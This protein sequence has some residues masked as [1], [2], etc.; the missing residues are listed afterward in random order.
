M[1]VKK[2]VLSA[3][4][5]GAMLAGTA[6]VPAAAVNVNNFTDV[7]AT[8]WFYSGVKYVAE[9]DY[10]IGVTDTLF[11]P[12]REVT[13]AMFVVI[14]YR[15][16]GEPAAGYTGFADVP[17]G[18]WC[19]K[20]VAW[21]SAN[22]IVKGFDS[23][24]FGPNSPISREQMCVMMDRFLDYRAK[25]ED[26]TFKSTVAEKT[27]QDAATIGD[28]AKEAVKTC[29]ML[30]LMEGN[31]EG[32]FNPK[33]STNRAE[34]AVVIQRLDTL[35]ATD[36]EKDEDNE[37]G[38]GG[39]GGGGGGTSTPKANY[40][41]MAVL[42][43]P[44]EEFDLNLM[45]QYNGITASSAA[46]TFSDMMYDLFDG[47]ENENAVKNAINV[48]LGK[49]KGK[50]V[51]QTVD[52]QQV[53]VSVSG[54]G[55]ISASMAVKVTD[56][57][58]G[59]Q[60]FALTSSSLEDLIGKLQGGGDLSF[61][62]EDIANMGDLVTEIEKV[63]GMTDKEIQDKIDEVVAEKPELEQA[64]SGMTPDAV[65]DAADDYKAQVNDVL[66]EV[67]SNAGVQVEK[68][69]KGNVIIPAPE[70]IPDNI[71]EVVVKKDP[72]VM[73][74]A[75]D[76]GAY[77]T[78]ILDKYNA[79]DTKTEYINRLEE[80][81]GL[82]LT[83]YQEFAAMGLYQVYNPANF[84]EDNGDKTLSLKDAQ[85]Y[86]E[87]VRWS[88]DNSGI[89]LESLGQDAAFYQSLLEK[90]FSSSE[91]VETLASLM[92]DPN[93]VLSDETGLRGDLTVSVTKN[94]DEDTYDSILDLIA[95]KN[96]QIGSILPGEMPS[97]LSGLL[98]GYTITLTIDNLNE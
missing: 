80:Q 6:A 18:T 75:M 16:D 71:E 58:G 79:E 72:V 27:F 52:G 62:K 84:V 5:A 10:M 25:K 9:K 64:V 22:G 8:D 95:G 83:D 11:A 90:R 26:R 53:T 42:D 15:L 29:Q 92:G 87:L 4:L 7:K 32:N 20:A 63:G 70:E 56:M 47:T 45:S 86:L 49:V 21:A 88:V 73:N 67:L 93:G 2:Q 28:F 60:T 38:G 13:R 59:V 19:S 89:L 46:P 31:Q 96:D 97:F 35:L 54:S 48:G 76:L 44:V 78:Q 82:T 3:C 43:V 74:V 61:S 55:V 94:V 69:D 98:G 65:K 17:D 51:T 34:M 50:T 57:T 1:N 41:V 77:Y 33:R 39:G 37:S 23:N 66:E 91:N 40:N 30:G 68:D 85:Q 81:L 14:L 36:T 12:E 24:T